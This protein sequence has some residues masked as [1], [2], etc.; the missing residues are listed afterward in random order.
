MK[1][2]LKILAIF[3]IV[4]F[5]AFFVFSCGD[6]LPPTADDSSDDTGGT[7]RANLTAV[8]STVDT[9][10]KEGSNEEEKIVDDYRQYELPKGYDNDHCFEGLQ[11]EVKFVACS[12]LAF[13]GPTVITKDSKWVTGAD[14][15]ANA[16]EMTIAGLEADAIYNKAKEK[17]GTYN[18]LLDQLYYKE[19]KV[20]DP[21]G[22]QASL[23]DFLY[24]QIM[25]FNGYLAAKEAEDK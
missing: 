24:G 25:D 12:L 6:D 5:G 17:F 8:I 23:V 16:L 7:S 15:L 20:L 22:M 10:D 14:V 9:V 3:A 4:S 11:N 18:K 21:V 2:T 1:N 13:T 19:Y